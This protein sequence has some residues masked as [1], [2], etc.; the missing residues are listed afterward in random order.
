MVDNKQGLFVPGSRVRVRVPVE[1]TVY[2]GAG[3]GHRDSQRPGQALR[4][5][6]GR[7]ERGDPPRHH[8]R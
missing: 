3:T 4:A 2:C 6:R 8:A 1:R 7:Q 5:G